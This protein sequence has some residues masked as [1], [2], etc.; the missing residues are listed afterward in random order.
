MAC[1]QVA[2]GG[3][4][5]K[6][7][8]AVNVLNKQSVNKGWSFNLELDEVLTIHHKTRPCYETDTTASGMD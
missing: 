4:A 3:T 8:V 6:I 7:A 2:G 1:P 5:C